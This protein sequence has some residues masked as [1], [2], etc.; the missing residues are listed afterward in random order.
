[1]CLASSLGTLDHFRHEGV[2]HFQKAIELDQWN[3][4]AYLQLGELYEAMQL[5][6]RV[7]PRCSKVLEIDPSHEV[8]R[9]R[10][11]VIADKAGTK[12]RL[13]TKSFFKKRR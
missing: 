12:A 1:V 9:R 11:T 6:W 7:E 4:G 2:E 10:L 8:A 3:P 5:P 13:A